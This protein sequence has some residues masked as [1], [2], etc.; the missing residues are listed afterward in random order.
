MTE[1]LCTS[2]GYSKQAYYKSL[3]SC[4]DKEERERYVLSI[5]EELRRDLPRLGVYKLWRMLNDNGLPV[6]RDWLFRLLHR[7]DLLVKMKKYRVVTTDSRAWRHQYPNLVKGYCV[8]RANQVWVSDITYLVTGKGV[9][10]LSLVTDAY[11]R[12]IMGWEVYP[13]LDSAG[14]VKRPVALHA[15]KDLLRAHLLP[16]LHLAGHRDADA[17]P[18]FT[19]LFKEPVTAP[20]VRTEGVPVL[21]RPTAQEIGREAHRKLRGVHVLGS[22]EQKHRAVVAIDPLVRGV[23]SQLP[24]ALH[25]PAGRLDDGGQHVSHLL[26]CRRGAGVAI[27]VLLPEAVPE[28]ALILLS[29]RGSL[30]ETPCRAACHR[31]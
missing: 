5:V 24:P 31:G 1:Y 10:Y 25:V 26:L 2:L 3:R 19:E 9:V 12:R 18:V 22:V 15:R 23:G 7:H 29:R 13:T 8:E 11:S 6:G 21:I 17:I 16:V 14:P 4:N 28:K 30:W 27:R 20:D